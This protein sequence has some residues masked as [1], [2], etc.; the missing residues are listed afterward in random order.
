MKKYLLLFTILNISSSIFT[1]TLD[2]FT[3]RTITQEKPV[4]KYPELNE[5]DIMWQKR[6][7]R[8]IDVREKINQSFLNPE[9]TFFE[10]LTV[11]ARAGKLQLFSIEKDDFSMPLPMDSINEILTVVDTVLNFCAF[12]DGEFVNIVRN[13]LNYEDVKRYRLK[14][15][16]YLDNQTSTMKVRILGIAPLI[17]V[18]DDNGNFIYE[19]PLFWVHYPSAR[20]V[21]ARATVFNTGNDSSGMTWEDLFEMRKFSSYIYKESNVGDTRL[22]HQFVGLELLLKADKIG[23]TIFNYENNL[24]SN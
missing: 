19:K 5:R 17:D 3:P 16:W 21:F 6:I 15:I 4:L 11:A 18:H 23:R 10:I 7:W 2:D 20:D 1:Q 9:Q 12:N 13:E 22:N 24:W 14:E 8:V